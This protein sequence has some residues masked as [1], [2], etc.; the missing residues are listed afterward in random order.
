VKKLVIT[1]SFQNDVKRMRQNNYDENSL[2]K[3]VKLLQ[4]GKPI[5]YKYDDH[6]LRTKYKGYRCFHIENDW[7]LIYKN[8]KKT[9]ILERTGTHSDLFD[10][11]ITK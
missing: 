3:S 6:P 1:Q 2:W 9:L 11:L 5:P 8:E 4:K 7:I 10:P